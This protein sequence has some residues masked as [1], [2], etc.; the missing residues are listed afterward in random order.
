ML[1]LDVTETEFFDERE[2]LFITVPAMT[3]RLEHSLSSLSKWES[4]THKPFLG[5]DGKT[6][7]EVRKYIK[8]MCLDEEVPDY[9]IDNLSQE[10]LRQ[11]TTY[12]ETPAT[13]TTVSQSKQPSS[14]PRE[15]IT[16]ELIYY[17]MISYTIPFECQH[18]H[19]DKLLTLIRVCSRKN[20][21]PRKMSAAERTALN[22][23]RRSQSGS[24][25]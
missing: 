20:E 6:P 19:L 9:V 21:T 8:C 1:V 22:R 7:E 15:T 13:A 11:V 3:L 16:A 2:E 12:I 14:A 17:W 4:I 10:Q 5:K 23:Q 18:W 24:R 25:G